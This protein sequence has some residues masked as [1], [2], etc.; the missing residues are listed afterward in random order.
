MQKKSMFDHFLQGFGNEL[1]AQLKLQFYHDMMIER[2]NQ[3]R[4][5]QKIV[6]EVTSAVLSRINLQIYNEAEKTI[7]EIESGQLMIQ[8]LDNLERYFQTDIDQV[9]GFDIKSVKI[10]DVDDELICATVFI[11]WDVETV[12]GSDSFL[13]DYS[14]I[15]KKEKNSYKLVQF[16]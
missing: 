6:D 5:R 16:Y 14:I 9:E 12:T 4:E 1:S 8:D 3:S 10:T 11:K 15:A 2:F 7:R 13:C